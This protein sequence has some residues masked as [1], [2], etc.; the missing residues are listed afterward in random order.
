MTEI[1]FGGVV[2]VLNECVKLVRATRRLLESVGVVFPHMSELERSLRD[3]SA[4]VQAY[5]EQEKADKD[6]PLIED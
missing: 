3:R 6:R 1:D 2:K 4:E 5:M